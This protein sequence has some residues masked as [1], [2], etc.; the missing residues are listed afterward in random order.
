MFL[1]VLREREKVLLVSNM[2][3]VKFPG[4]AFDLL[5]PLFLRTC[6]YP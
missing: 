6:P 3:N 4:G 1:M 2:R 5:S